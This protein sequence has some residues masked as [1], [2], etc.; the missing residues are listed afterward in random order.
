MSDNKRFL[1]EK[2]LN[3]IIKDYE[4][5]DSDVGDS[6]IDFG[7]SGSESE[8]YEEENEVI[9]DEISAVSSDEESSDDNIPLAAFT[10]KVIYGKNGHKWYT[11]PIHSKNR[12]TS[13]KNLV[14][15]FPGPKNLGRHV[16]TEMEAWQ[17]FFDIDILNTIV[18]HT[19]EEIVRNQ[20][21]FTKKQRYT[22]PTNQI[23]I[24]ALVGLLYLS[25]ALRKNHLNIDEIWSKEYGPP[26]FRA[27]MSKNRFTFLIKNLRFD[28][29][30]TRLE[31]KKKLT[32]LLLLGR[33]G[34]GT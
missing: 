16:Q 15:H 20:A 3:D 33:F 32:S 23:E 19:N 6:D 24:E 18:I 9:E 10:R 26:I 7:D 11:K 8:D 12:R 1:S 21:M 30:I 5:G 25:G 14:K 27:T 28:D 29:K 31:R 17:L 13:A 22:D 2:E 34:T 4:A